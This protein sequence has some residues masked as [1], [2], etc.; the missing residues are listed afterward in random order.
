M[1]CN[2]GVDHAPGGNWRLPDS[3]SDSDCVLTARLTA[4]LWSRDERD[5]I[6]LFNIPDRLLE[7]TYAPQWQDTVCADRAFLCA[8]EFVCSLFFFW[9]WFVALYTR[10]AFFGVNLIW[11]SQIQRLDTVIVAPPCFELRRLLMAAAAAATTDDEHVLLAKAAMVC[12]GLVF[13][14]RGIRSSACDGVYGIGGCGSG[15]SAG[16][17]GGTGMGSCGL[18]LAI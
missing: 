9:S 11:L 10:S 12:M 4:G 16:G 8:E 15:S 7:T 18:L 2:R 13:V 5:A 1:L 17:D 6:W 14:C 3:D